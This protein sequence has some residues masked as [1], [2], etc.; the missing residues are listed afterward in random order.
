M[1]LLIKFNKKIILVLVTVIL[2]TFTLAACDKAPKDA[3]AK[4]NGDNIPKTEF[5]KNFGM[6]KK[7]YEEQ[8]GEDIMS[9]DAGNGMT[10]EEAIKEQVLEKLIMEKII[11]NY[12]K[13][14]EITVTDEEVNE[15]IS[16]YKEVLGDEEKYKTF[17]TE[18][19]MTEE[20]FKEGIKKEMIM[21]KYRVNYIDGLEIDE[22]EAK[23]HFEEYKDNYVKVRAS[24]ILVETEEEAKTILGKINNGEDFH[25]LAGKESIDTGTAVK[26]GDLG[27]FGK[28]KMVP[29]FDEVAFSLKPGEV[30]DI[31]QSDYGYHIIKVEERLENYEDVKDDVMEDVKNVKYEENI[32]KLREEAKVKIYM[33]EEKKQ[34][35][36]KPEEEK[37]EK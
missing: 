17:L 23:K 29:E 26:G 35:E 13:K 7:V 33:E 21:D 8:F 31:V 12:A 24:H 37:T 6:Y 15:Q 16:S 4:V 32:K 28:G 2:A 3:I 18:N 19:N 25:E 5:D 14:N 22:E 30:S 36:K 20:Y 9:K 34:E 10:F 11:L 1:F 27:Y